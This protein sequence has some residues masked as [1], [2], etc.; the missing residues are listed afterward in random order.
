MRKL[1]RLFVKLG[2]FLLSHPE[3]LQIIEDAASKKGAK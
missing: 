3:L 2:G 1:G